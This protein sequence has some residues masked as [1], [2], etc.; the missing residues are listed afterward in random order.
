MKIFCAL[1]FFCLIVT[2][3]GG[4]LS[5]VFSRTRKFTSLKD[6]G[7]DLSNRAVALEERIFDDAELGKLRYEIESR[8]RTAMDVDKAR[9]W[10]VTL[11]KIGKGKGSI[12]TCSFS[13]TNFECFVP[14]K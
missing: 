5:D 11:S 12:K 8:D 4:G 13:G 10:E 3:F 1:L 7:D 6:W 9:Q 14:S 2:C